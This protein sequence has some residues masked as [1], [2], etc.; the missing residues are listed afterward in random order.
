MGRPPLKE[1]QQQVP[2]ALPRFMRAWIE[3]RAA[4]WKCSL[5]EVIRIHLHKVYRDE[6]SD[7]GAKH[8]VM[9][10]PR[11]S[12]TWSEDKLGMLCTNTLTRGSR[13]GTH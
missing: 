10:V 2:V 1:K 8:L 12:R 11:T 3:E 7:E 4:K 5:A 9:F 13:F 6:R